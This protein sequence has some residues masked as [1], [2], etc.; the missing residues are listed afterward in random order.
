MDETALRLVSVEELYHFFGSGLAGRMRR[1]EEAGKLYN[2]CQFVMGIPARRMGVADSDELVLIQGIIDAWFEED[3]GLVI[4]DYKTDRIA[5]G[6]EQTLIDRYRIQLAYYAKAL[7]QIAGK[8]VKE[9]VI[10]S[11]ALQ[12]EI[13][14]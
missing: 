2:E 6:E 3:D 9:T 14:V 13:V 5:E 11:M 8:Q 12:R 1:A 7:S 4:V 10:Y